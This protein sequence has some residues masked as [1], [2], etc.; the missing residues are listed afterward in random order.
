MSQPSVSDGHVHIAGRVPGSRS[1]A[2]DLL[3]EMDAAGVERAAVVT[4]STLGWDNS[5]TFEAVAAAP[6][7]FVAVARVD[8]LADDGIDVLREVIARGARGIRITLMG[9]PDIGWLAGRRLDEA[10]AVA[11]D[12]GT[13]VEFHAEPEQLGAVGAFAERHAGVAVLI[14]HLGRPVPGTLGGA[15]HLGFLTLA[16][17]PNV[18]TKSPALGFFSDLGYPYA[19][20]APFIAAAIDRFGADR[21]MWSSDWPGCYEFGSYRRALDGMLV[22]LDGALDRRGAV[23]E[24][25][26]Q[27]V[28]GGTFA[29]LFGSAE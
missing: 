9:Q 22:A 27:A 19:D 12:H 13:V 3:V 8:L 16:D 15:S 24:P 21:V 5:V 29:R 28:L 1:A 11:A 10:A 4:P 25:V 14:D 26:R 20:I 6:D 17:L 2:V 7:R 23:D 18:F